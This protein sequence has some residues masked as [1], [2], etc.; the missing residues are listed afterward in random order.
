[1]SFATKLVNALTIQ[2]ALSTVARY[3]Q[4]FVGAYASVHHD[5]TIRRRPN[6]PRRRIGDNTGI[7][8]MISDFGR[9]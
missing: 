3:N 1:M 7:R 4:M 8:V 2:N 6:P 5:G 9:D